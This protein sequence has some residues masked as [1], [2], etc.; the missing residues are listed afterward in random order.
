MNETLYEEGN[1]CP[2][3]KQGALHYPKVQNCSC[4]ISPPCNQC[5]ENPL[6][7]NKCGWVWEAPKRM[8][9]PT[10][11]PGICTVIYP[12]RRAL[13]VFPH[14]GRIMDYSYDARSGS[15]MVWTGSYEG[16]VTAADILAH[17]GD[18][19]FGHRGPSLTGSRFSYTQITD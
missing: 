1:H 11:I 19:S 4:H 8:I 12:S 13:H 10:D 7:C 17:F 5:V 9:V 16:P 6:T 18:G 15:T 3:C 14:G 2:E